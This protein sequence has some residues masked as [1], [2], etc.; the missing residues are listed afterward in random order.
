MTE[1]ADRQIEEAVALLQPAQAAPGPSAPFLS[2]PG[3]ARVGSVDLACVTSTPPGPLWVVRTSDEV[4]SGH[5]GIFTRPASDLVRGL[6]L[7]K[8]VMMMASP[9]AAGQPSS[10]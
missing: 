9:A 6:V 1:L 4:I 2:C 10:D 5:G 3:R 7:R 8:T